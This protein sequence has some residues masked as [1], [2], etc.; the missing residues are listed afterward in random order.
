M[1]S[2]FESVD[3]TTEGDRSNECY[4][5]VFPSGVVYCPEDKSKHRTFKSLI[6]M[7]DTAVIS[8]A[9]YYALQRGSHF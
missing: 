8:L 2:T 7:K 3:E 1:V 4:Q 9:V 5:G 6:Q